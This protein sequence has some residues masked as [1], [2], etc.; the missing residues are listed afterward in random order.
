MIITTVEKNIIRAIM[1]ITKSC[2]KLNWSSFKIFYTLSRLFTTLLK[3]FVY[4]LLKLYN[5]YY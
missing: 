1:A 4:L 3:L 2:Q 5:I